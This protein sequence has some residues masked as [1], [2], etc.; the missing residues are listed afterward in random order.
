[1]IRIT[2]FACCFAASVI[3]ESV[4]FTSFT[5]AGNDEIFASPIS[6]YEYRNPILAGYYPDPSICRVGDD[7][8]LTNSTFAHFPGLPIFHS[9]DMVNWTQ[10]GNA[11]DRPDQLPYD[12]AGISRALFAPAIS[13][14][15]GLFY[16]VCTMIDA[17]GNFL[18]TAE[19]PA[20]PWSDPIWLDF[21]GIDP[22][23]YFD[24][25]TGRAWM[26]NNGVPPDN[27]PLYDGHRAVWIQEWD[28]AARQL[29]GPRKIIVNGGVDLSTQPVWI[30]GPH[31]YR[32][33]D[34]YY[35]N[36]AEG[37]TS[38]NHS[39]VIFRSKAP[40]GLYVPF[41]DHPTLTQRDLDPDRSHPVTCTGHADFEIGPDG[42]WWSIFLACTPYE[43]G[44][45]NT[46]RQ[47]FL[48]P[49]TW[50][51]DW[52]LILPP[53]K[54]V[55][56]TGR[57][58]NG[59]GLREPPVGS[60]VVAGAA[61]PGP[62]SSSGVTASNFPLTGNFTWR[63]DFDRAELGDPWLFMRA[64]QET[65]WSTGDGLTIEPRSD[66]LRGRHNPS[67]IGRRLQHN[68]FQVETELELP[69]TPGVEAGLVAY[70]NE[71]HHYVLGVDRQD[72]GYRVFLEKQQGAARDAQVT[73]ATIDAKPGDAITLRLTG[74]DVDYRFEF[75]RDGGAS[76]RQVGGIQDA[77]NLSVETSYDFIGVLL[78]P[79]ARNP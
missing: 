55:P 78:G 39:Q 49:V 36:C 24:E 30:E 65:W 11:I 70:H 59:A 18:I 67:F 51:D 25:S 16:L 52:P 50:K 76:W 27:A 20:G 33:G 68:R 38:V 26:L 28:I 77:R 42:N 14:H 45:Y 73:E 71:T 74:H 5:Y 32:R 62:G 35:L 66:S 4:R 56:L 72:A 47:T 60:V 63:D 44:H 17:G 1:M 61:D 69:A 2:L 23:L 22:S 46:G 6:E 21:D 79:M 41:T 29:I 43:G 15:D 40:D 10:I 7:Y 34:W 57:G 64:P 3:A 31:I 58:P 9:K 37:G 12:G 48:L 54:P 53:G 19:D 8:Y 13:Y 75:S